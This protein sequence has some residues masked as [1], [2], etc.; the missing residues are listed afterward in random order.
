MKETING[1]INKDELDKT[2]SISKQT[3]AN[4]ISKISKL[5]IAIDTLECEDISIPESAYGTLDYYKS[6][7][8]EE[9]KSYEQLLTLKN[10]YY[11]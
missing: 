5:E 3:I 4:L 10:K 1:G 7:L 9:T 2:L 8:N 6:K 11:V